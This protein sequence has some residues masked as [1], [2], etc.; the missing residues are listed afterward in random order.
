MGEEGKRL[1]Y[2]PLEDAEAVQPEFWIVSYEGSR[3]DG[4]RFLIAYP[5]SSI[6]G[7]RWILHRMGTF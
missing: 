6:S 1:R 5:S 2:V 4:C 7:A 3:C